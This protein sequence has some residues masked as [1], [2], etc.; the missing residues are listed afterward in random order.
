MS[1][2]KKILDDMRGALKNKEAQK[3]KVLRLLQASIKN[4]EIQ[5]RPKEI[6]ESDIINTIQKSIKQQEET[7]QQLKQAGRVESVQL[8][9]EEIAILQ[10]YLPKMPSSEEMEKVVNTIIA[11]LPAPSVKEMGK[12]MQACMQHFKGPVD[13]KLLSQKVLQK[14]HSHKP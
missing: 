6:T 13:K 12:V 8:E 10:S 4:K 3:L 5:L 7:V 11:D 2:K 9:E 1:L 14:L